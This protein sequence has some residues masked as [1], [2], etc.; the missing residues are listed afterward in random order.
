MANTFYEHI[1][2]H[3]RAVILVREDFF[4]AGFLGKIAGLPIKLFNVLLVWQ[5]RASQRAHLTQLPDY[6]IEDMGLSARDV[7][8]EAAKFFWQA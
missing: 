6:L 1:N 8:R 4:G 5:D 2:P 3:A 7:R